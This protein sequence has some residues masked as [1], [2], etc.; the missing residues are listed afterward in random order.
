M[1]RHSS[2]IFGI[3]LWLARMPPYPAIFAAN[4]EVSQLTIL[5]PWTILDLFNLRFVEP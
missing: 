3:S 4:V 2:K 5:D 1:P